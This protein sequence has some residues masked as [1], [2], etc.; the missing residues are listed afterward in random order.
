MLLAACCMVHQV[1]FSPV[2]AHTYMEHS[3][4]ITTLRFFFY[5]Q[6]SDGQTRPDQTSSLPSARRLSL[7]RKGCVLIAEWTDSGVRMHAH[8][9][10][11]CS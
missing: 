8:T 6:V 2:K 3:N 9:H 7:A 11:E 5:A 1:E 10:G 4:S